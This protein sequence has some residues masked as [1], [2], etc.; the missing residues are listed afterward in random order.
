LLDELILALRESLGTTM[1][2]VTHE[3]SSIFTIADDAVFLD[4]ET[5]TML[6]TGNPR[7]LR[8]HSDI[9]KVRA[10]LN[11]GAP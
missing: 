2:V 6:T 10:F 1:V 11:R 7:E 9:P 5:K 3:L 8:D 4:P